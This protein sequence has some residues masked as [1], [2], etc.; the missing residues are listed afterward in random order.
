M[1]FDFSEGYYNSR[2][3]KSNVRYE[4]LRN[5]F[6]VAASRA[7][8]QI[9]Y[10]ADEKEPLLKQQQLST[11]FQTKK[12]IE[13]QQ[14]DEMFSFKY[15][16]SVDACFDLLEYEEIPVDDNSVIEIIEADHNIDLMPCAG[17]YQELSYFSSYD[18]DKALNSFTGSRD[19]LQTWAV[20]EEV[21][22]LPE[23][24][25]LI[26]KVLYLTACA[27]LHM[28]YVKQ[29][30]ERFITEE[31]AEKLHARLAEVFAR[32]EQVQ[33]RCEIKIPKLKAKG[34]CDVLVDD[35]IYELK[36]VHELSHEHF[37]QLACYMYALDKEKGVLWN[38]RTN[39]R[40]LVKI[41]DKEKFIRYV[42]AT[43]NKQ[44][45]PKDTSKRKI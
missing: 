11:P 1:L 2:A 43:V 39:E 7:K 25:D 29:V 16:E 18:Y 12:E 36:F 13:P 15:K 32:D 8:R 28:R 42:E 10:V 3:S 44:A 23:P 45:I 22:K 40:F 38:T 41:P 9:I 17:V 34:L 5:I 30:V 19:K 14:I 37:L 33:V 31:N 24:K 27:T 26:E 4:I 35:T 21:R 6:C 20:V